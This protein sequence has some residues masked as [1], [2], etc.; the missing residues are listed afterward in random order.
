MY[1][2]DRSSRRIFLRNIGATT[3]AA[4]VVGVEPL[5]NSDHSS[6]SASQNGPNNGDNDRANEAAKLRRIQR[7]ITLRIRPTPGASDQR[8]RGPLFKQDR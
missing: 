8:R 5:L 1:N 7:R 6:A 3:L 2:A 4:G